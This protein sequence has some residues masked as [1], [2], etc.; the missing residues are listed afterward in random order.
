MAATFFAIVQTGVIS[1]VNGALGA[2]AHHKASS[3]VPWLAAAG[4]IAAFALLAAVLISYKAWRLLDDPAL[5]INTIRAYLDPARDGNPAVG[6]KLVD[7]Y[8]KIAEGRRTNNKKRTD[9]LEDATKA[10]AVA[11]VCIGIELILA[12]VAVGVQ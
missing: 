11:F 4:G 1:L 9:A 8:S 2:S 7:A 6:A 5:T 3:F 12:F 10:C